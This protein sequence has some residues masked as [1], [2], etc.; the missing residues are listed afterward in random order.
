MEKT[1]EDSHQHEHQDVRGRGGFIISGLTSGHGVFHW[2]T[3]SFIAML[4]EVKDAFELSNVA[5]G[6]ITTA[7]ELVSGIVYSE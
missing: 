1:E 4:P 2:F 3:Q 7:R 6:G 5:V